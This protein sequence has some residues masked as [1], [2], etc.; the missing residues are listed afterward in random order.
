MKCKIINSYYD[1]NSGFSTVTIQNKRGQYS[2][3]TLLREEDKKYESRYAGCRYAELKAYINM[4][5]AEI[6]EL[7]IQLDAFEKFYKNL[8]MA[9][10]FNEKSYE[11]KRLRGK[12]FELKNKIK[13]RTELKDSIHNT[14]LNAINGRD[15]EIKEFYSKINK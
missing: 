11:A 9:K 12:I 8:Q 13:E 2:G 5:K 14:L 6:K 4:I 10:A 3:N 15:Q 1:E 7:K